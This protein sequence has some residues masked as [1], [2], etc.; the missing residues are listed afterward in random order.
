MRRIYMDHASTTPVDPLVLDAMLPYFSEKFGNASSNHSFGAEAKLALEDSRDITAKAL[1]SKPEELIFTSGGTESD[2]LAIKGVA[3]RNK[4]RHIIT[5]CIEHKAVLNPCRSLEERGFKVTYL[6]VDKYGLV[7]NNELENAI[8]EDTFLIS[9]MHANNEIGTI[10][11]IEE[12]G[13]IAKERGITFHT[14]AVQTAGKIPIDMKKMNVDLLSISSH[15]LYG[16][17]G[18]GLL[19]VRDGAELE[20]LIDGGGHE[21]GLRSGTENIPGIVGFSRALELSVERMEKESKRQMRL[22]DRLIK[23]VL[24]LKGCGLNGHPTKRLPNNAHF[25]LPAEGVDLINVLAGY[26]I[27]ASTA[28]A[29]SAHSTGTSHVLSAIGLSDEEACRSLRLTL[30]RVN[31]KEDIGY[32]IKKIHNIIEDGC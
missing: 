9:V 29:C 3:C 15:K 27:A 8:T 11:P 19:Y 14:D 30:G 31:T 1:K 2:N 12:I 10:Q 16:P 22:R 17:K 28:S 6:P 23:G 26:G 21:R 7:D 25:T 5:N 13:K 32:V 18:V 4:K 20:P 24:A